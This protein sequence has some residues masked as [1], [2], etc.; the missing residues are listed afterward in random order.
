METK[1]QA[2]SNEKPAST[3]FRTG[4]REARHEKQ[5]TRNEPREASREK[6]VT[7]PDINFIRQVRKESNSDLKTCMQCGNCTVVCN[8]SPE[9]NPF[10]RKEMIW[11]AWGQK[12]KLVADPDIWLCHQCGD[13]TEAC[14]RGVKPGDVLASLRSQTIEYY[15]KPR[16]LA[17]WLKNPWMLP[18][19]VAI[20]MLIIHLIILAAGTLTNTVDPVNYSEFFPHAWIN[21]SFSALALLM[22]VALIFSIRSFWKGMI[23]HQTSL[24]ALSAD[25]RA[26]RGNLFLKERVIK[27]FRYVLAELMSHKKFNDC[28]VNKFRQVAHAMVFYGFIGLLVVTL[29]AIVAVVLEVYPLG[30]WHPIKIVG[31][32]AGLSILIGLIM[33]VL[34]RLR[35]KDAVSNSNY[36]DWSFLIA[37]LLLVLTGFITEISR[38]T[39]MHLGYYWYIFHLIIMW[40]VI[41]FLP[42]TKFGHVVYRFVALMFAKRMGK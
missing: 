16:F 13:C 9:E 38:F 10:P 34:Q 6:Q 29:A 17:K 4:K 26:K 41:L 36:F 35:K 2:T 19:V 32:L 11:A 40:Y 3:I 31:N 28:E 8:L 18:V 25:R 5:E 1:Q 33:M 15:A 7:S 24:P 22:V 12:E 37:M 39:N 30:L 20:P 42:Y 14:P 27:S 23:S 21:S